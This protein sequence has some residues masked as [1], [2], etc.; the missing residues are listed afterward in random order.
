[1]PFHLWPGTQLFYRATLKPDPWVWGQLVISQSLQ[2]LKLRAEYLIPTAHPSSTVTSKY[3]GSM[4]SSKTESLPV[5]ILVLRLFT[6]FQYTLEFGSPKYQ[7]YQ[8]VQ[9]VESQAGGKNY[10]VCRL[11]CC[12]S[13]HRH[14]EYKK[15]FLQCR[16]HGGHQ[17]Q[18]RLNISVTTGQEAWQSFRC[19]WRSQ[20]SK[21]VERSCF[22]TSL[23]PL[24]VFHLIFLPH[25][26]TMFCYFSFYSSISSIFD[27]LLSGFVF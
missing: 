1:M 13:Q 26:C 3:L 11:Q 4:E 17:V 23:F 12:C 27:L 9:H 22:D 14:Q 25:L 5:W 8:W 10:S 20:T 6:H 2:S 19:N 16:S 21:D 18:Y 15:E 24:F 7:P